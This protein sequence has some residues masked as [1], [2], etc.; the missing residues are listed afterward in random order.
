MCKACQAKPG[1][2]KGGLCDGCR[3]KQIAEAEAKASGP[4][5]AEFFVEEVELGLVCYDE[6]LQARCGFD[7]ETVADYV[8]CLDALPPPVV[9][10]DGDWYWIGDGNHRRKAHADAWRSHIKVEVRPN[11]PGKE[12]KASAR[13]Y[14]VGANTT[15]G[16]RR[17]NADK[18][19]AVRMALEMEPGMANRAIANHVGVDDKTVAS[20]RKEMSAGAEVPHL[21]TRKGLDGKQYPVKPSAQ[22][23]RDEYA[24]H[25]N[26]QWEYGPREEE[27]EREPGEEDEADLSR[28]DGEGPEEEGHSEP[29]PKK[30]QTYG[31]ADLG[32]EVPEDDTV[33]R[34][35]VGI[36]VPDWCVEAFQD[37]E[38]WGVL[39]DLIRKVAKQLDVVA[40]SPGAWRLRDSL[41]LKTSGE[42][43]RYQCQSL[44]GL[45][46]RLQHE[47]PYAAVCVWCD[48]TCPGKPPS[49]ACIQCR[50]RG[51]VTEDMWLKTPLDY[52]EVAV[53]RWVRGEDV[54]YDADRE[55]VA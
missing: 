52:R 42:R 40:H 53:A 31:P 19:R 20:V 48:R 34:D 44:R 7:E 17:T 15:H 13:W 25:D 50:G 30:S 3:T 16:L 2:R 38:E 33:L 8:G 32:V 18:R 39:D 14:A 5:P 55:D 41:E 10:F 43:Q 54:P 28:D 4:P 23:T 27:R 29:A 36:P 6:D 45:S 35:Q 22:T 51:W 46:H 1:V 24:P 12:A 26:V 11:Y 37:L 47:R 9:F 49:P 21:D